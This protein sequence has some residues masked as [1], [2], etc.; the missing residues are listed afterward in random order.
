MQFALILPRHRLRT[1]HA[2]LAHRL[3]GT[4]DIKVFIDETSP[5]YPLGIRAWLT[6]E[7]LL[8]RDRHG[9]LKSLADV[10]LTPAHAL[11]P[12][13]FDVVIDLSERRVPQLNAI[14]IRYDGSPDSLT[15][16]DRLLAHQTPHLTV[17]RQGAQ[18]HLAESFP[19][20]DDKFQLSRGLRIASGRCI[21][22]IER[23]LQSPRQRPA[24]QSSAP[25]PTPGRLADF[26][27]RFA[28]HKAANMLGPLTHAP[29]WSV[30]LRSNSGPFLPVAN[31]RRHFY[32]DP[33]L[34]QW[35]GRTFLFVEV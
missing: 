35:S 25:P 31:E 33:F 8:Y 22:L 11:D 7:R 30:A 27:R 28:T 15:L 13:A 10:A 6:L 2:S 3:S 23:A 5:P 1:W 16:I 14:F 18:E 29:R 24:G 4:H 9:G 20:I 26:I 19:A 32:A 21:S 34:Y 12:R 17:A